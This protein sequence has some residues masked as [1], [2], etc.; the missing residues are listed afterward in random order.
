MATTTAFCTSA[1]Q[2]LA[3]GLHNFTQTTGNAF[4]MALVKVAPAGTY[5]AA[6]TNY[7]NLTGN[8]DEVPNGNGYATGG[9]AWTAAQNITPATAGTTAFWSWTVN[10]SW[11]S[12]TFSC[13]AGIIYNTTNGNRSVSTHD[14]GGTQTVSAGTLTVILPTNNNTSAILR[15]Q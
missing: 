2:E 4:S 6:T 12:A 5:G 8:A 7:S 11:T 10:P 14:F 1:K 9:F 13:T 3:Q 15:I